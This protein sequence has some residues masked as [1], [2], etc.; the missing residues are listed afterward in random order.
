M[1]TFTLFPRRLLVA[2]LFVIGAGAF[3]EAQEPFVGQEGKDVVY[4]PTPPE[5]VERMLDVAG[6]TPQDYVI[7]LGSGDGRIVTAAAKR[8][9]RALGIEYDAGLVA[10]ARRLAAGQGVGDTAV[11]VEADLFE[12]DFSEATVLTTFLLSDVMLKLRERIF[13]L[14]PGTRLVSNSFKMEGWRPDQTDSID[15]CTTWCTVHLW[16]VPAKVE[17]TWRL[18]EGELSLKQDFQRLSG[19]LTIRKTSTISTTSITSITAETRVP[20][21]NGRLRGDEITFTAG[22]A[23]YTGRVKDHAMQGSVIAGATTN[24]WTADRVN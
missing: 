20:I 15:G 6:V 1:K 13:D 22:G 2:A 16:I 21:A 10:L 11:F 23:E 7:D 4:V 18:P 19:T 3:P 9:A 17:G 12:S 5:M 24:R 14:R 8:G